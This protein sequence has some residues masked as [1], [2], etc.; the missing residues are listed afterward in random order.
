MTLVFPQEIEVWYVLPAV[1]R[2]LALELKRLGLTHSDI[3]KKLF[4]TNAAVSQYLSGKRAKKS[5]SE[6]TNAI[7]NVVLESSK[8]IALGESNAVCEVTVI[9]KKIWEDKLVCR[10]HKQHAK[11]LLPKNCDWCFKQKTRNLALNKKT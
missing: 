7:K 1:R 10:L 9:A 8:R 4:V 5:S 6:I 3:A 11:N 2:E